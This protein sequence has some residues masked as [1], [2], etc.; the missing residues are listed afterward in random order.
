MIYGAFL[1]IPLTNRFFHHTDGPPNSGEGASNPAGTSSLG[2]EDGPTLKAHGGFWSVACSRP[3]AAGLLK[4]RLS[5]LVFHFFQGSKRP[6]SFAFDDV[7]VWLETL[8]LSQ[9]GKPLVVPCR[10]PSYGR[11]LKG[12]ESKM[13]SIVQYMNTGVKYNTIAEKCFCCVLCVGVISDV[14][15]SFSGY[16][17]MFCL[18][19]VRMVN[20]PKQAH[21]FQQR[22]AKIAGRKH[23]DKMCI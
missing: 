15:G 18:F 9:P 3:P 22:T 4:R 6:A 13:V 19:G 2:H 14:L 16:L 12:R 5:E 7:L 23:P 1:Q 20:N 11:V 21:W 10:R 8:G 17:P